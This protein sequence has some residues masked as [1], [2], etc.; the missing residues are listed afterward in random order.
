MIIRKM[1]ESDLSRCAQIIES[2]YSNPPYN[3]TFIENSAYKYVAGEFLSCKEHSFVVEDDSKIVACTFIQ[4]SSWSDGLQA[5]IQEIAVDPSR[6][7]EGIGKMVMNHS[8]E[9]LRSI[10]IESV[11]IWAKNDEKVQRFY[12]Q[13]NFAPIDDF[14]VMYKMLNK[15]N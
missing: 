6:Q 14:V 15:E 5:K 8:Y 3:E 13:Q 7:G 4:I 1:R 12:T 10:G 2:A 11:M 9:Y